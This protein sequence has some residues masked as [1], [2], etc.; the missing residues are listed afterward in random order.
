M[1]IETDIHGNIISIA[2]GGQLEIC[3][4]RIFGSNGK[5]VKFGS[6]AE[7]L[8]IDATDVNDIA[9]TSKWEEGLAG[10]QID[11]IGTSYEG[12]KHSFTKDDLNSLLYNL[13]SR[14]SE[15][16]LQGLPFYQNDAIYNLHSFVSFEGSIYISLQDNNVGNDLTDTAYWK[17]Y[18]DKNHAERLENTL[19]T[20]QDVNEIVPLY[21]QRMSVILEE[22]LEQ[23]DYHINPPDYGLPRLQGIDAGFYNEPYS[24]DIRK[25]NEMTCF[26]D[27]DPNWF[28]K[29]SRNTVSLGN[30]GI[31]DNAPQ[32]YNILRDLVINIFPDRR[33]NDVITL[34]GDDPD[35]SL[36]KLYS[37]YY[38]QRYLASIEY[39]AHVSSTVTYIYQANTHFFAGVQ[40]TVSAPN[41]NDIVK[42][43]TND[44][45]QIKGDI[46]ASHYTHKDSLASAAT[47]SKLLW[48]YTFPR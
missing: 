47:G 19:Q 3:L 4:N 17:K 32:N 1:K 43:I 18:I 16:F 10:A 24:Y 5:H 6:A 36:N 11:P 21:D 28:I 29:Y 23:N 41:E 33:F 22:A 26:T 12:T 30:N 48:Y 15:A 38:D 7:G 25:L 45:Q 44:N 39:I 14:A 34:I 40:F 20:E 9:D 27:I 13:S 37:V 42:D 31:L 35:N 46:T 8:P 2:S